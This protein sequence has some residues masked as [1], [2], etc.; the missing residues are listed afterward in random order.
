MKTM[1][2]GN[3]AIGVDSPPYIIAEVSANHNGSIANAIRLIEQAKMC[4]AS[5]VKL[6]TYTADTLTIE[7]AEPDFLIQGG[8]WSG[9]TLYDLYREAGTPWEWHKELFQEAQRQGITIFSSPFDETAVQLLEDLNAPAYKVASFEITDLSLIKTVAS[10]GKPV[11]LSTGLA[12]LR[13]IEE[14][15]TVARD[16]GAS[17]IALL[18]CVSSYPA[19]TKEYKLGTIPALRELFPCEVGLSDHSLGNEVAIGAIALGASIIEKHF[20]LDVQGAGPDDSFSM[21]AQGL[22]DLR[23]SAMAIWEARGFDNFEIQPS[24]VK[25]VQFRRS[26]YIVRD[27]EVGEVLTRNHVRSIRP[28]YGV[29]PKYLNE[30]VG[31]RS[32]EALKAGARV[33][34]SFLEAVRQQ[35]IR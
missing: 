6:Q 22:S 13:E 4:G 17:D 19:P 26:L 7:S 18:H 15:Y 31:K 33:T 23:S 20:T 28:G 1:K 3:V 21:N 14:A 25:N 2:I 8:L 24:E 32:P 9:R 10:T 35:N 12:N 30:L 34:Q 29:A 5:A 16:S 11:I 27:I